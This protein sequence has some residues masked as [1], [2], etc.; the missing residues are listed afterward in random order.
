MSKKVAGYGQIIDL[1]IYDFGQMLFLLDLPELKTAYGKIYHKMQNPL[2]GRTI[3]VED[4]GVGMADYS[5]ITVE[6]MQAA[7][8]NMD[9]V[10]NSYITGT[11]ASLELIGV[12]SFGGEWSM[13][14]Q[15]GQLLPSMQPKLFFKGEYK[16]I[17]VNCDLKAYEN[18]VLERTYDPEKMYWYDN[19]MHWYKYLCGDLSDETRY[20]TPRIG[21]EVSLLVDGLVISSELGRSVSADEIKE[22]SESL[23]I[24]KQ[25]TPWGIFDYENTL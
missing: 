2:K 25:E 7:A 1:G 21:L 15:R 8:T 17:H 18:Q 19:Q 9:N 4:M 11:K 24:W 5:G 10:G 13:G 22:R 3:E 16:G 20:D 6:L 12:D 14:D 23:A